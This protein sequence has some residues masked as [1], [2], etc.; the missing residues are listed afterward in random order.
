MGAPDATRYI[1]P[2]DLVISPCSVAEV[3][4]YVESNHYSGSINGVKISHCFSVHSPSN[5]LVGAVIYGQL[6]TTAWKRYG[7]KEEDVLE[8][9]RLVLSDECGHNS[10]SRV[11]GYTLRWIKANTAVKTVVSYADPH[12]GH[13]G[14]IYQASNFDYL[15]M[16]SADKGYFDS[17]TGKI[18]HSRALRT[19]YKG[20][21]KPFVKRLRD[22][23]SRGLLT[24]I[25][26]PGKHI[27]VYHL[28]RRNGRDT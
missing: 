7:S 16:T 23:L 5:D 15:G 11:V 1:A 25:E 12:Y 21:Y 14:V 13:E 28:R 9:R 17:E 4:E 27:Y 2:L 10:E 20:D 19:K 6:S 22:R 26:L 8:L 24:A 18:Y 3:R